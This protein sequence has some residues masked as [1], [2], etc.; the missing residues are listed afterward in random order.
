MKDKQNILP[1]KFLV[2]FLFVFSTASGVAHAATCTPPTPPV[3]YQDETVLTY[4]G[5]GLQ[6][7]GA[8]V[9]GSGLVLMP[10]GASFQN[11]KQ[12]RVQVV[13]TGNS[14]D[15][16][17]NF[18]VSSYNTCLQNPSFVNKCP[19]PPIVGCSNTSELTYYQQLIT[20]ANQRGID[21]ASAQADLAKCQQQID[22]YAK[23]V[24]AQNQ[25]M[26]DQYGYDLQT[27]KQ[28]PTLAQRAYA[29]KKCQT[30]NGATSIFDYGTNSCTGSPILPPTP[31]QKCSSKYGFN[32]YVSDLSAGTCACNRGYSMQTASNGSTQCLV[33]PPQSP[34]VQFSSAPSEAT[35]NTSAS[36]SSSL[37]CPPNSSLGTDNFCHCN[38]GFG[39]K[40]NKCVPWNEAM[41]AE[42]VKLYGPETHY[43]AATTNYECNSGYVFSSS[44]P[45]NTRCIPQEATSKK[46][47]TIPSSQDA[48]IKAIM[49]KYNYTPLSKDSSASTSDHETT[50]TIAPSPV[51][52]H[53]YQWLNPINWFS[54]L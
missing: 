31:W 15:P 48:R 6:P 22:D 28:A 36:A 10:S 24:Q 7:D 8:I 21:P 14:S 50:N 16:I 32:S 2:V 39:G 38:K 18:E 27:G 5:Y 46:N 26:I 45:Q 35:G 53:W 41:Q 51:R 49:A 19:Y 42:G 30:T 44:D 20:L 54:W 9:T 40:D 23:K 25:C 52:K 13:C 37:S 47:P 3:C 29:D 33:I 11:S 34:A 43:N 1:L 17:Y 12:V 4:Q